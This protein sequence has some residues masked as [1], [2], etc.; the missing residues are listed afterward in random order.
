MKGQIQSC[1]LQAGTV[2]HTLPLLLAALV[3]AA[4]PTCSC[5]G[6]CRETGKRRSEV[7]REVKLCSFGEHH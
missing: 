6:C 7:V 4:G 1:D 2:R 5:P 3:L